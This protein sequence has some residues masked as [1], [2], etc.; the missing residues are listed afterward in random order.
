[1]LFLKLDGFH[2]S[3]EMYKLGYVLALQMYTSRFK[4]AIRRIFL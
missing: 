2:E 4:M 3:S 1:M